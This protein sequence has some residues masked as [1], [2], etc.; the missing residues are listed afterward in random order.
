MAA[1]SRLRKSY[2]KIRYE[3]R[4]L[5][6]AFNLFCTQMYKSNSHRIACRPILTHISSAPPSVRPALFNSHVYDV[7]RTGCET[8]SHTSL[9]R[10][11]LFV[12][13]LPDKLWGSRFAFNHL[14]TPSP[15]PPPTSSSTRSMLCSH[16]LYSYSYEFS[17]TYIY[18]NI[19]RATNRE[20]INYQLWNVNQ[21]WF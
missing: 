19:L 8:R 5:F 15:P 12:F 2:H 1:A 13:S 18:L 9:C 14:A 6:P 3:F 10:G 4:L 17:D 7:L 16:P 21:I 20:T 11:L